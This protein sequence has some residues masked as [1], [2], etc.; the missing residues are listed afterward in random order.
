MANRKISENFALAIAHPVRAAGVTNGRGSSARIGLADFAYVGTGDALIAAGLVRREWLPGDPACPNKTTFVTR[1]DGRRVN[2]IRAAGRKFEIYFG[3]TEAEYEACTREPYRSAVAKRA[4]VDEREANLL[5]SEPEDDGDG[6]EDWPPSLDH[7][8]EIKL[9]DGSRW[10]FLGSAD[11][12]LRAGLLDANEI[13]GNPACKYSWRVL[14]W[15]D[16]GCFQAVRL[17]NSIAVTVLDA[18]K[19]QTSIIRCVPLDLSKRGAPDD[20]VTDA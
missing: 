13:P 9:G 6:N 1:V 7:Q 19:G 4:G 16:V 12:I 5:A 17:G 8:T 3:P 20:G 18:G 14:G 10:H 11:A 15:R 2:V